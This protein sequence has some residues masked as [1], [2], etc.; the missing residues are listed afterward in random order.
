MHECFEAVSPDD[1]FEFGSYSVT[2]EEIVSFA[3]SYDPQPFHLEE[4]EGSMFG[5]IVASGWHTAAMSMRLIVDNYLEAAGALGA[6]GVDE[7]RWPEPVRPGDELSVRLSVVDLEPWDESRG[8]VHQLVE[9]TN[10]NGTP[11]LRM[12]PSV[13]YR[14]RE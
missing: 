6:L 2:R 12:E 9:T 7:L 4:S 11:V 13:L 1:E 8:L 10:Q 5:G 3:S 14:R